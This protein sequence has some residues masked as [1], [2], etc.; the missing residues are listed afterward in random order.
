MDDSNGIWA[1]GSGSL[2][3]PIYKSTNPN[4]PNSGWTTE[5]SIGA[6]MI[7]QGDTMYVVNNITY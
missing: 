2:Q 5:A 4:V 3:N 1:I 7:G 6:R